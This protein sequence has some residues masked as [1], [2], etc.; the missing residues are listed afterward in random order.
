MGKFT[1]KRGESAQCT[2]LGMSGR[3]SALAR[4]RS[5]PSSGP[6][7]SLCLIF[8]LCGLERLNRW[9]RGLL[10]PWLCEMCP[11]IPC[12]LCGCSAPAPV[13]S[14]VLPPTATTLSPKRDHKSS[15]PAQN[16]L[17]WKEPGKDEAAPG[18]TGPAC[19]ALP[20]P[21][22]CIHYAHP[23]WG[24]PGEPHSRRWQ[25]QVLLLEHSAR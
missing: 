14:S 24:S 18:T 8:C 12:M 20:C 17:L 23:E 15:L 9:S 7:F 3:S 22:C 13:Q 5:G 16:A 6:I 21:G 2:G 1:T 4:A 10:Q 11:A 19:D 25:S